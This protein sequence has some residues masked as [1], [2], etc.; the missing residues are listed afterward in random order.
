MVLVVLGI[1]LGHA[2]NKYY[3]TEDLQ[4]LAYMFAFTEFVLT[5]VTTIIC[6]VF[7]CEEIEA[8]VPSSSSSR[9]S[10]VRVGPFAIGGRDTP[11]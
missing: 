1:A 2:Y 8:V 6:K 5:D 3:N 11:C 7:V 10:P 4:L 9:P